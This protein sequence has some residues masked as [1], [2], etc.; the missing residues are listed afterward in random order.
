MVTSGMHPVKVFPF[1]NQTIA[2]ECI[3]QPA[4]GAISSKE[5]VS[6][7]DVASAFVLSSKT[8]KC[9]LHSTI[10][11]EFKVVVLGSGG[12]GKSALTVQFVS[13]CFMEKYD[14]TIEDFYRKEI[15]VDNSPCVLEILDTAGTEQFA[16]MRDLYIKNGQGFVVVYSLTNH[17]TFQDIKPMKELI[18]RV[19]GSERVP[20]LL[21]G[22]KADLDH[23]REVSQTEGSAL[24]QMWGCPFVEASAKSRT[25]VNEMFAEIVRE[26]NVSPEKD[27]RPYCCCTVL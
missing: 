16:S 23:Q 13:G 19:K 14:P 9:D 3:D 20:I 5:R 2:I 18:T 11:R 1:T 12:V 7:I 10:M 17:Q 8:G 25:N 27:K 6:W 22:N 26:M 15:E 4:A 21:V 24:A